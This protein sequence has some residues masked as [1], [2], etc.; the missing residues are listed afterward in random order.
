[1]TTSL[2]G[3]LRSEAQQRRLLS[4]AR[5]KRVRFWYP[6]DSGDGITAAMLEKE[7]ADVRL[8]TPTYHNTTADYNL[9]NDRI[10]QDRLEDQATALEELMHK[11]IIHA[12]LAEPARIIDV[13]CGTG[14]ETCQLGKVFPSAQVYGIDLSPVPPRSKPPNVEFVQGSF[15]ELLDDQSRFPAESMDYVFSRLLICGEL[16]SSEWPW[17]LALRERAKVKGWDLDCGSNIKN[18]MEKAGFVD[19]EQKRYRIPIGLWL[20]GESPETKRIGEH[21]AKE[22]GMLYYYAVGQM[23]KGAGYDDG[24]VENFQEDKKN[25]FADEDG[26]EVD[27]FVTIGR[28]P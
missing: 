12:P 15:R 22:Y 16:C 11:R 7:E 19:V 26:K 17:L 25:S 14:I 8:R 18:Y 1:M 3:S 28:K 4:S 24:T 13:G 27:F 6:P 10:E 5:L 21:A 20:A 9:P 23:L 2:S